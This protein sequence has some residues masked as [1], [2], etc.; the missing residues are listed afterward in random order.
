MGIVLLLIILLM[1][2]KLLTKGSR[3]LNGVLSLM[4]TNRRILN[5]ILSCLLDILVVSATDVMLVS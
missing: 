3:T 5:G 2:T 1:K 4:R